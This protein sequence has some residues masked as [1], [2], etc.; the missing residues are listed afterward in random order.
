MFVQEIREQFYSDIRMKNRIPIAYQT[1]CL[2]VLEDIIAQ[3]KEKNDYAT[4]S[5]LF[6]E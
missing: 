6:D 2:L 4:I 5:E 3:I 1:E